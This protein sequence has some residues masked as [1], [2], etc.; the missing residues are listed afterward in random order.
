MIIEDTF[1]RKQIDD[2]SKYFKKGKSKGNSEL[3]E[4]VINALYL[5]ERLIDVDIDL[6]FKGG[7]ALALLLKKIHRFSIDIDIIL[8]N[9]DGLEVAFEKLINNNFIFSKFEKIE[10]EN[11]K[12]VPK[13]HYKFFFT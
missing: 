3:I 13:A 11:T 5:L 12:E 8:Q 1:T 7:T 2:R 6:I 9:D 10:R 4:K